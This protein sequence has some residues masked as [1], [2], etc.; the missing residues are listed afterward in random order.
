MKYDWKKRPK[1]VSSQNTVRTLPPNVF[2]I[3]VTSFK[4]KT[5]KDYFKE[6]DT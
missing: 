2:I 6:I 3:C 5:T 4:K 1:M